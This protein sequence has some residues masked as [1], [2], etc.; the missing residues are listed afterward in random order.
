MRL[1]IDIETDGLLD[2]LTKVHCIAVFNLDNGTVSSFADQLGYA[3]ISEAL[4]LLSGAT[5]LVAH[6]GIRFDIPALEA[7]YGWKPP[8][9]CIIRDTLV[10]GQLLSPNIAESD[11]RSES[12]PKKLAGSH[13]L[14]AWGHRLGVLKGNYKGGWSEWSED[15][16]SYMVQ[17]IYV[18]AALWQRIER[19]A[20][21]WGVPLE[22]DNPPP[23]R[24]CIALEHRVAD[25]CQ[26]VE[27]YG[28]R[29]DMAAAV[30]LVE[31]LTA[32][33]QEIVDS[34]AS[35]FPPKVITESFIP[36]V[37]NKKLGYT[38]GVEVI[39]RREIP[40]N[41]GSRQQ[42]A[43]RL[44][45]LGWTPLEFGKDGHPTVDDEILTSLPYPEAKVLAEYFVVEKRL[46]QIAQGKEA[47]YKHVKNGRIYGRINSVGAHTGRMTHSRPNLAQVPKVGSPYGEECRALFL[48]DEDKVL[49]G[50]DADAL[51]LRDLAG[52]MAR[53]DGGAYIKTVLEG[54]KEDGTDMHSINAK[55]WN[56]S[57]DDAKT[58]FYAMIYGCYDQTLA[59][60]LGHTGNRAKLARVGAKLRRLLLTRISALG[61]L[62][63]KV[64]KAVTKRGYLVSIDG[65]RL[66]VRSM[67]AAINTL[68]Q[69]AGA[70]QMKRAL[71]FLYDTCIQNGWEWG[72]DFAIVL[73]VHDEWQSNV[74]PCIAE[75]YGGIAA[76]SIRRAGEFY[77]FRCPLKGN[78]DIGKN[79]RET[80]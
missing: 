55:L 14:E 38:R 26:K 8:T 57:R 67:N 5:L 4:Q 49:V 65:R 44:I 45:E 74:R 42:V 30:E 25:I 70:V 72:T 48:A 35:I 53:Y 75:E 80:H 29:F 20:K 59:A 78:Y 58:A 13:S 28:V 7:V 56:A 23:G 54:R 63:E 11:Y 61:A 64:Q 18:T 52:Y 10:L 17:D 33:R 24:D 6:N 60:N 73:I 36:K 40:F 2:T 31:K 41:P 77:S 21:E 34:L 47:W 43:E 39:K 50:C 76:D 71:V 69:S 16:H 15:M 3:P 79:W 12:F 19:I 62:T 66:G 46:G 9:G 1:V 37:N 22:D 32:R 68:L 51:E 27:L